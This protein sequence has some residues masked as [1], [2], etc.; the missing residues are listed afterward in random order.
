MHVLKSRWKIEEKGVRYYGL[1][2]KGK[3]FHNYIPLG[4][5]QRELLLSLPKELT[6][7]EKR[8]LGKRLLGTVVVE[9]KEN[10]KIPKS[11]EEARFCKDCAANDFMIPGLEFDERGLCPICQ[12]KE[13]TKELRSIVPLI[14]EIPRSEKSRFDV[15]LF[16]TGGKD[17]TY[18][19]YLL[20]KTMGL[21]VLALT[22]E[23]PYMSRSAK[24]SIEEAKRIF[25]KVEFLSRKM[26]DEDLRKIY[27]RLMSLSENVC[28]CPSLAYVLFYPEL[29][30]LGVPYF[31]AGNEPAQLLG[32][33]FNHMAPKSAYR[34]WKSK[35]FLRLYNLGRVLTLRPPLRNGGLHTLLTMKQLAYGDNPL[36]NMA[37][38][39]NELVS[40]VVE[41]I[42][43]VPSLL[44]PLRRAIRRSSW[45][46]RVPSFVQIDLDEAAGGSYDWRKVM[47][48]LEKEA[49]YR[50]PESMRKGLHTS[51]RI[52]RCK[53]HTQFIRF[54]E[55]R[56]T[57]I[58]FSALEMAIASQGRNLSRE[59]AIAEI[60]DELG[61][62]LEEVPECRIMK[63]YLKED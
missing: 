27:R 63:A 42:H 9:E 52:E 44:K 56:S 53:E 37:G 25:P 32:L 40:N 22:W 49:G 3:L 36:K 16:Y 24:E 60:K 21:R 28:A 55:M 26:L 20:S 2:N 8:I 35:A 13:E 23:I 48:M 31:L 47:E 51:C 14:H 29:V 61:F 19:L 59:E 15:A 4:K 46:G 38:Y 17:S 43:E 41:A 39:R 11:L 18:L 34:I 7:K 58:P 57:M 54:Y 12:M 10:P 1:R 62:S 33:Y 50:P 30:E 5:R 6:A 45:T